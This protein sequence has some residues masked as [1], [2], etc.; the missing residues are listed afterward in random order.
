MTKEEAITKLREA[1]PYV[2]CGIRSVKTDYPDARAA[3]IIAAQNPDGGG[4]MI[5]TVNEPEELFD[6]IA[7]ALDITVTDDDAMKHKA[8]QFVSKWGLNHG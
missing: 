2:L 6:S 8:A 3:V 1:L 4:K 7:L 5:L